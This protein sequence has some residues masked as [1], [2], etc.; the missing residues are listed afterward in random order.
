M[1]IRCYFWMRL[2]DKIQVKT[3]HCA[4]IK[5]LQIFDDESAGYR[6]EV[7]DIYLIYF[8]GL[9]FHKKISILYSSIG[10]SIR[11]FEQNLSLCVYGWIAA[12]FHMIICTN[13]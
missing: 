5:Y 13:R 10:E 11:A 7:G 3:G 12:T 1:K 4:Q 8:K 6:L 9:A 2:S